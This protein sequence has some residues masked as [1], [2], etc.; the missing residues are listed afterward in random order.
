MLT[1]HSRDISDN[2]HKTLQDFHLFEETLV[3]SGSSMDQVQL[4]LSQF[5][6][7][8][9]TCERTVSQARVYQKATD[10]TIHVVN[11][12]MSEIEVNLEDAHQQLYRA[13]SLAEGK[14][15]LF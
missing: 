11:S 6:S 1:S 10:G 12:L 13:E 8:L 7:S 4:Q 15:V 5:A 14:C 9:E 3:E 2:A